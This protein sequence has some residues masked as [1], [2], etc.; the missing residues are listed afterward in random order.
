MEA[1][2][3]FKNFRKTKKHAGVWSKARHRRVI[4]SMRVGCVIGK[5]KTSRYFSPGKG[6]E[7]ERLKLTNIMINGIIFH[8]AV[9]ACALDKRVIFLNEVMKKCNIK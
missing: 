5:M 6:I 2:G 3:E 7:R 4:C 8:A 9:M 1:L